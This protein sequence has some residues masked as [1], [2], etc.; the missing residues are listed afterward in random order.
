MAINPGKEEGEVLLIL[1]VSFSFLDTS[2]PFELVVLV[3][4]C[5][6]LSTEILGEVNTLEFEGIISPDRRG[7][8]ELDGIEVE[9]ADGTS[10]GEDEVKLV[11]NNKEYFFITH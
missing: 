5:L 6:G 11:Y 9:I 10:V 7:E 4:G 8:I 2:L 1:A 3:D